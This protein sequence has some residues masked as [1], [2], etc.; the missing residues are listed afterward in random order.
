MQYIK[1]GLYFNFQRIDS[2]NKEFNEI[3]APR[4][5]GKTTALENGK[6]YEAIKRGEVVVVYFRNHISLDVDSMQVRINRLIEN[7]DEKIKFWYKL[8][9]IKSGL[10]RV[11]AK[12]GNGEYK[13]ALLCVS[14]N[15]RV[16]DIKKIGASDLAFEVF[17]EYIINPCDYKEKYLD[18]EWRVFM[19]AH[20]TFKRF[21]KDPAKYKTYF[22]GNAYSRFNPFHV[23]VGVDS[24]R[25][26]PGALVVGPNYAIEI[27]KISDELRKKILERNPN[28][29][30]DKDYA[31][32][33]LGVNYVNDKNI[34]LSKS[35]PTGFN[36]NKINYLI[37]YNNIYLAI[38]QGIKGY[39]NYFFVRK[40]SA[41]EFA[42][43]LKKKAFAFNL[44][45][46]DE[47]CNIMD[48]KYNGFFYPL[49]LCLMKHRCFFTHIE[50]YYVLK[51]LFEKG[52]I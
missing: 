45:D 24:N 38:Y 23:G 10:L 13:P 40:S 3:I 16:S 43:N 9:D 51:E 22:I 35:V 11:M 26:N 41:E 49:R 29:A 30:H 34:T 28:Y 42:L 32:Y 39:F 7:E 33:A 20:H 21:A 36:F 19:E 31:D 27:F 48:K 14:L 52:K 50:N 47:H 46:V 12:I 1:Q 37:Y 44:D 25:L 4:E 18:H 17:D 8:G 2:C 6:I 15:R 5:V